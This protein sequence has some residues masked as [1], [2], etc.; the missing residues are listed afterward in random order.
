MATF[1]AGQ[2]SH[3]LDVEIRGEGK[4]TFRPLARRGLSPIG[5][6]ADWGAAPLELRA[7]FDKLTACV[8]K[9]IS[10]DVFAGAAPP[11][12]PLMGIAAGGA[13]VPIPWRLVTAWVASVLVAIALA[14]RIRPSR[15]LGTASSLLAL[16]AATWLFR[17]YAFPAAFFH[18]NGHGAMW[19][20][21]ALGEYCSY[22][23]GFRELFAFPA[24]LDS[25]AA[26]QGIFFAHSLLAATAPIS[27]WLIARAAGAP[28]IVAW[29]LALVLAI[30]PGLGRLAQ[31]ESYFG[32][33][34]WLLLAAAALLA[35]GARFV[36]PRSLPFA[37]AVCGAGALIGQAAVVHPIAWIPS[38]LVPLAVLVGRGA[39]ERR[40]RLLVAATVGTGL[41]ALA[42]SGAIVLQVYELHRR[43]GQSIGE[44]FLPQL[45]AWLPWGLGLAGLFGGTWA[46]KRHAKEVAFPL[47]RAVVVTSALVVT[48]AL[49]ATLHPFASQAS[50]IQHVAWGPYLPVLVAE[51]A[52][53]ASLV[54]TQWLKPRALALAIAA[55]AVV[56]FAIKGRELTTLPTDVLESQFAIS[57]RDELPDGARVLHL[58]RADKRISTL[59][60]YKASPRNIKAVALVREKGVEQALSFSTAPLAFYYRSSLCTS[61]HGRNYCDELERNWKLE[62]IRTA[63]LPARPSMPYLPYDAEEVRVGLYRII[64]QPRPSP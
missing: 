54:P 48:L 47:R 1:R 46:L 22:G 3:A 33:V 41:V 17:R 8:E 51:T 10:D 6:F 24:R 23:P 52:A 11:S 5:E 16:G 49:G 64:N 15:F 14:R 12:N 25:A 31:S 50:W 58:E 38:A 19:V 45:L 32:V 62:P 13:V 42:S 36:G 55:A 26:E 27:A 20:D 30:N 2:G 63:V 37:L 34:T 56:S 39:L 35:T 57:W 43:W 4:G 9:G 28:K 59:P 7:A 40:I 61:E 60:L 18:Q 21:C 53:L 29:A 44:G